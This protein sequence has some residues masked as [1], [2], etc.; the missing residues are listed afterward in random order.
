LGQQVDDG[1]AMAGAAIVGGD[2]DVST[3]E[4]RRW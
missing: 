1:A 2:L 3:G 4:S